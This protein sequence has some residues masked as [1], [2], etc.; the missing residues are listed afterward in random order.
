MNKNGELHCE[1]VPIRFTDTVFCLS[2]LW[3]YMF[4]F[5]TSYIQTRAVSTALCSTCSHFL[6]SWMPLH[7]RA[8]I[9]PKDFSTSSFSTST[10]PLLSPEDI[11]CLSKASST[12]NLHT[13][14]ILSV[15]I[16]PVCSVGLFTRLVHPHLDMLQCHTKTEHYD[17]VGHRKPHLPGSMVTTQIFTDTQHATSTSQCSHIPHKCQNSLFPNC[18]A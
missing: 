4:D 17:Q 16:H 1:H 11:F 7:R 3:Y 13:H 12:W 18:K 14:S 8:T 9:L 15:Q 6:L 10:S 2:R 5:I